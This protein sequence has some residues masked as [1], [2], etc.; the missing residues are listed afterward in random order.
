MDTLVLMGARVI[1]KI[2][3]LCTDVCAFTFYRTEIRLV[4]CNVT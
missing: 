4:E 2:S 3:I 1:S